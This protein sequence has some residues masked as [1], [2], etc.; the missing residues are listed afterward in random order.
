MNNI[1]VRYWNSHSAAQNPYFYHFRNN[2][3]LMME[4]ADSI[5]PTKFL[6]IPY[7]AL[8]EY[9]GVHEEALNDLTNAGFTD[10]LETDNRTDGYVQSVP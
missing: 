4:E 8:F 1:T 10:I 7:T 9:G 5:V 2:D 3:K 6:R